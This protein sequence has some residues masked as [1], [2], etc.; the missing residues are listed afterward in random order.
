MSAFEPPS[1]SPAPPSAPVG[2]ERV[3]ELLA[4]HH[5]IDSRDYKQGTLQRRATRRMGLLGFT[6]WPAYATH[7]ERNPDE[8]VALYRDVLIRVTRFFRDPEQ[9]E[10]LEREI[11]PRLLQGR[12]D[13]HDPI[14]VWSAGCATGEEAYGLVMIF[15]EQLQRAG[16]S[17]KL[18]VFAT[19]V[20]QDAVAFARKGI[21]P[22]SIAD[23]V[24]PARL[25]RFFSPHSDGYQI[26]REVR[27]RVT[28]G[29]HDLLSDPPFSW[30]DLVACRNL[31]IYLEPHAQH[32]CLRRFHFSLLPHG[33]LW[34]GNAEGI[35]R[36]D[37]MF[38][39]VVPDLRVYQRIESHRRGA[40]PWS[41]RTLSAGASALPSASV[42]AHSS[43]G[44]VTGSIERFVLSHRTPASVVIDRAGH[45]LRLFGPT[46]QY[47]VHPRGDVR[48]EL[49]AWLDPGLYVE[50]RPVLERALAGSET[51]VV[52]G[53]HVQRGELVAPIT[54]TIE[55]LRTIADGLWLVTFRDEPQASDAAQGQ[56]AREPAPPA[57]DSLAEQLVRELQATKAEL[58]RALEDIADIEADHR[59]AH[60]E[61]LSINEELQVSNDALASSKAE[62]LSVNEELQ[63]VNRE[64]EERNARL[65]ASKTDLESLLAVT[66]IPTLFLDRRLCVR[67]FVAAAPG[68]MGLTQDDVGRPLELIAPRVAGERLIEGAGHVLEHLAK[69]EAAVE[70]HDGHRYLRRMVPYRSEGR[71]EGV[72]IT[73]ID[74]MS[75][76][77]AME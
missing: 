68:V 55:P 23:D 28:M 34:L 3:L 66:T 74:V 14:R 52:D 57:G 47:L 17:C 58:R 4:R 27:E 40:L 67:R 16:R 42:L 41:I 44:R 72:C 29:Y 6:E 49:L 43:P 73:F 35:D 54:C 20:S 26:T 18:Q 12:T 15:I 39:P 71:V 50:L 75:P 11:V 38:R 37:E 64:L 56:P 21:Y 31:L 7:L 59:A 24:P 9:W 25:A 65:H 10:H 62:A 13:E 5:G 69:L 51:V 77:L 36:E 33:M 70:G 22:K 19:D 30:L 60:E 61:L 53:V 46:S 2:F 32:E 63:T 1:P 45:M 8:L 48:P 76:G